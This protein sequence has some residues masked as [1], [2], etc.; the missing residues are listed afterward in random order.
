[1][2]RAVL[3]SPTQ[4]DVTSGNA[5][6]E[7]PPAVFSKLNEE[8]NFEIDLCADPDRALCPIYFGPGSP[9]HIDALE[10]PWPMFGKTVAFCN[11][12]YGPFVPKILPI[13]KVNALY[14]G[15][16]SVFLIPMRVTK[17]FTNYILD[18]AAEV[19]F[20]DRRLSFYEN[21]VPRDPAPFDSIIVV[22]RP[23]CYKPEF[24]SWSVPHHVGTPHDARRKETLPRTGP[25]PL[26]ATA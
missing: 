13:A 20:C 5:C 2:N 6:W 18:G 21:G 7:T 22:Y 8:F 15:F 14:Y 11:P 19:R 17:A 3:L 9:Y 24:S 10:A 4:R 26:P 1:M 23:G 16:T 12:P 25:G